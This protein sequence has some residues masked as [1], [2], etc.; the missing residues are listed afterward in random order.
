MSLIFLLTSMSIYGNIN[1]RFVHENVRQIAI[2]R[3]LG[4]KMKSIMKIYFEISIIILLLTVVI[5]IPTT[6]LG[7]LYLNNIINNYYGI[8]FYL[9]DFSILFIII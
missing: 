3:T 4:V 5:T 6:F 1:S 8:N 7:S 9:F 2:L